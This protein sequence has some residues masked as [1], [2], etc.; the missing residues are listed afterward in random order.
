MDK[1]IE[2]LAK[3]M[4]ASKLRL[5][6]AI[7]ALRNKVKELAPKERWVRHRN[8]CTKEMRNRK[9]L[10]AKQQL[11]DPLTAAGLTAE[12]VKRLTNNQN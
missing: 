2:A 10:Q 8:G 12:Q 9:Y 4:I 11:K 3:V 7:K 1:E 5:D 6:V